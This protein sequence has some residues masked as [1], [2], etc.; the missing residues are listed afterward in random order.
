MVMWVN[1]FMVPWV[2]FFMVSWI[3]FFNKEDHRGIDKLVE[4]RCSPCYRLFSYLRNLGTR[5]L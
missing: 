3:I 1:L 5:F 2:N 4:D